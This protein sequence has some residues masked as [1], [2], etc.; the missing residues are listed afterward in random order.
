MTKR[1]FAS[2]FL[3]AAACGGDG[4]SGSGVDGTKEIA[5]LT[6]SE[7][8]ALCNWMAES[9][10]APREVECGGGRS[11]GFI[12]ADECARRLDKIP[13]ACP[14]TVDQYEACIE[15]MIEDECSRDA[16]CDLP[17]SCDD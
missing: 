3:L 16:A 2:L 5:A 15:S 14:A 7:R 11:R 6:A 12:A 9:L 10:D 17:E 13:E 4:S 1:L 8:S